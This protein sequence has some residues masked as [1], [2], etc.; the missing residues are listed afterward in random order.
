MLVFQL[1][2]RDTTLKER[3]FLETTLST[4]SVF[5]KFLKVYWGKNDMSSKWP[6]FTIPSYPFFLKCTAP[7]N[8][9]Y[10]YPKSSMPCLNRTAPAAL[11]QASW[12]L[13]YPSIHQISKDFS[14]ISMTY[15]HPETNS[16]EFSGEGHQKQTKMESPKNHHFFRAFAVRL[17]REKIVPKQKEA[18]TP[19]SSSNTCGG[20][21][22]GTSRKLIATGQNVDI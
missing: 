13:G 17:F 12:C 2:N 22:V 6:T 1:T 3:F 19:K 7:E 10:R 4:W 15:P 8:F 9:T 5:S 20:A 21:V 18:S 11:L 16:E 14:K